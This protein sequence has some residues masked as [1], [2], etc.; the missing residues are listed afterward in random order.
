M[1]AFT[2]EE[3]KEIESSEDIKDMMNILDSILDGETFKI[4]TTETDRTV[5]EQYKPVLPLGLIEANDA[6]KN[7]SKRFY[8]YVLN[9]LISLLLEL[10]PMTCDSEEVYAFR[11]AIIVNI[12]VS[13]CVLKT[14]NWRF[15]NIKFDENFVKNEGK[16]YAGKNKELS[17]KIRN[18]MQAASNFLAFSSMNMVRFNHHFPIEKTNLIIKSLTGV[19]EDMRNDLLEEEKLETFYN[20]FV[21]A[22]RLLNDKKYY[23]KFILSK[24]D[25]S[26]KYYY[27]SILGAYDVHFEEELI[28]IRKVNT[29]NGF[30]IC[31]IINEIVTDLKNKKTLFLVP[32]INEF[33]E[34]LK[35]REHIRLN[36]F[37][38]H[39][40][41][42]FY[43]C[44]AEDYDQIVEKFQ[45]L[46]KRIGSFVYQYSETMYASVR[47]AKCRS[48]Y[49]KN[50]TKDDEVLVK[51][52]LEVSK[53][54]ISIPKEQ[55]AMIK[56]K[57]HTQII[58]INEDTDIEARNKEIIK[59]IE[60]SI[61]NN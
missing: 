37:A 27:Y 34:I 23:E 29:P 47:A 57:L 38:Y 16:S 4:R 20:Q 9:I 53:V 54:D 15:S 30:L 39:P 14:D 2:E 50:I 26:N 49:E 48:K 21:T 31:D 6:I 5:N 11:M 40:S 18:Y 32:Y 43:K 52:I 22:A 8:A 41:K 35:I 28:K 55:V 45:N 59:L 7:K 3:I 25:E 17:E 33:I 36:P 51:I 12:I 60:D 61:K 10:N 13:G 42:Y 58:E 24:S 44:K 19:P 46:M 56:K 1:E